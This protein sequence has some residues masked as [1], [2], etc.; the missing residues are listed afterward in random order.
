MWTDEEFAAWRARPETKKFLEF[1]NEV[2]E[3]VKEKWAEGIP[4]DEKE[5]AVAMVYGDIIGLRYEQVAE[6][7]GIEPPNEVDDGDQ[8]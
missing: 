1:L 2:R 8:E 5:H 3:S 4:M 7:Y 6:V